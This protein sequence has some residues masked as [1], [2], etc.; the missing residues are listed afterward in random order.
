MSVRLVFQYFDDILENP[1]LAVA[2]RA[3]SW[4]AQIVVPIDV[5]LP[6]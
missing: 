6:R 4:V 5:D 2:E 1:F 3:V